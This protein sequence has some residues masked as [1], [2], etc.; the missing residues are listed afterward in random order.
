MKTKLIPQM[1]PWFDAKEARALYDYMKGGGWA[2]EFIETEK[3]EKKISAFTRS[4]YCLMV[5][6]GT[7]SLTL[8]LLALG[9]KPNDEVLIPDLTMIAS[10]NS[11][12]LVGVKPVLVDVEE[13]TLC[14]DLKDAEKKLTKK[15]KALM[16]VAFNGRCGKMLEVKSFCKKHKLYLIE[17]SAQALGSYFQKKHLGTFGEIGSF[18]FSP[19]KIIT[20]GQ[21]GA[22]ITDSRELFDKIKKLKDFGRDKGGVDFHPFLGWNFKFTDLQAVVGLEQMKKLRFRIQRKKEIY[23][24][25]LTGLKEIKEI[26]FIPTDLKQ[27]S[28]WFIDIYVSTPDKLATF[29][30]KK[31]IGTR[32]IYPAIHSQKIYQNYGTDRQFP[33]AAKIAAEGLWLPSSTKLTGQQVN[34]IIKSIREYY[35]KNRKE[36]L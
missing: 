20:T 31:G 22:L 5:N 7:V 29:L 11:C 10:P 25:Y 16:Y 32:R 15:T 27:T 35:E 9:I 8:A 33:I 34:Y 19:P 30:L 14:L 6:N 17:D 12:V 28:P 4:K 18:S 23:R 24:Q 3:L 21:G 26:K 36:K 2:T 13:K 1:E